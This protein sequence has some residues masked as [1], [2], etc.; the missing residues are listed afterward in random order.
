MARH[1]G[2]RSTCDTE[3]GEGQEGRGKG[4][5]EDK[6]DGLGRQNASLARHWYPPQ[7]GDSSA[8][9]RQQYWP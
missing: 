6:S 4:R 5:Q 9:L 8:W 1:P 2:K 3:S 7:L